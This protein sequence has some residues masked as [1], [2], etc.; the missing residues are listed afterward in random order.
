V[1]TENQR[2]R[3]RCQRNRH[4]LYR[5]LEDLVLRYTQV[6]I[7]ADGELH[8]ENNRIWF[9]ISPNLEA[10]ERYNYLLNRLTPKPR[11]GPATLKKRRR[12]PSTDARRSSSSVGREKDKLHQA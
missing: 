6:R 4:A 9:R 5:E 2:K 10:D 3:E 11:P 7:Q 8:Q 1:P 12:S